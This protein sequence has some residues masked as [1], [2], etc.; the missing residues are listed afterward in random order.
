M[1]TRLVQCSIIKSN[2]KKL[3]LCL[4]SELAGAID[5]MLLCIW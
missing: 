1:I 4:H 2:I 3:I 5:Q